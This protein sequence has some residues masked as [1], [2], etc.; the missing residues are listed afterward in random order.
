MKKLQSLTEEEV[1]HIAKL[2]SLHLEEGEI[3][4]FQKQLS[5]ILGYVGSLKK[6]NTK[7][8]NPTSQ[9]TGLEN[10]FRQDSKGDSLSQ[11]EALA[12]AQETDG[13][14]FKTKKIFD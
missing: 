12:N 3:K 6:L 7:T 8:I 5:S 11:K 9:V 13:P 1:R 4:K 2:A 10:V 14:Y